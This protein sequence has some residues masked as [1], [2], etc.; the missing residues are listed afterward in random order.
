MDIK[1]AIRA[2]TEREDLDHAQ[3]RGV[4]QT[5]MTGEATP[6][7]V[8][9]FLV[10]L[11][12]KGETV[13]E[14]TAAAEVM[15]EL[16][17]PLPIGGDGTGLVDVVGT[18]GDG[19]HTFNISTT[20]TFVVAGSGGRVAKHGNR[21]VSSSSG[22]ADLLEAAGVSLELNPAQV[23]TCV[24]E[25]GVG[26]M[27]AP[28]H[29]AAMKHAIGPRREMA[30]RTVFNLLGPLTNPARARHT[31]I[32]V[33]DAAWTRP[34]AE[35]LGRLGTDHALVVHA[36]DGLDEISLGAITHVAEVRGG[37][38][39]NN[40]VRTDAVTGYSVSEYTIDPAQ[41]GLK[42]TPSTALTVDSPAASLR[43]VRGVLAN[44]AG[45][46]RDIVVANSA[47]A[48]YAADLAGS[49]EDGAK[50]A[51]ETIAS[52][53]AADKLDALVRLSGKL[54]AA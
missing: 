12:M 1:A 28:R 3:M 2:V 24:E 18:G 48:L 16:A 6:S 10:G 19:A 36:E 32:G 21:D 50:L 40:E 42:H 4:M 27:F 17:T 7:Q 38:V 25:I 53:R 34:M 30:I 43:V 15:R 26:F 45:P 51:L 39:R 5:I 37:A 8:G 20:V 52:G 11:R 31:L 33:Y 14:I 49:L 54:S 13:E 46:A 47:A 35:T 9:G 44:E 29:H 23:A 22:A 41:L